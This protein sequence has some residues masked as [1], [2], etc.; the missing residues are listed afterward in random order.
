MPASA[1]PKCVRKTFS[2]D[3]RMDSVLNRV[4]ELPEK[5]YIPHTV[6]A[7]F[8]RRAEPLTGSRM[9]CFISPLGQWCVTVSWEVTWW[10]YVECVEIELPPQLYF[11]I[12]FYDGEDKKK[13]KLPL[14]FKFGGQIIL[15]KQF[16]II[17]GS[18]ER[19]PWEEKNVKLQN[20]VYCVICKIIF[21]TNT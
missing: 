12:T 6:G 10:T 19:K 3:I 9:Q 4:W 14:N 20:R 7:S 16:V 21:N 5:F 2:F 18:R 13:I 11:E 15:K 1:I 8:Q 17:Y